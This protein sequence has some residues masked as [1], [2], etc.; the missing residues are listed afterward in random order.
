M[1]KP[2]GTTTGEWQSLA[3]VLGVDL[4]RI[5]N[6]G[7]VGWR[8]FHERKYREA[9]AV[10]RGLTHLDPE[11]IDLYRGYSMAAAK[12]HDLQAAVEALDQ[13]LLLLDGKDDRD[14]DRAQLLALR[15]T[16]LYRA[17]RKAEAMESAEQSLERAPGAPWAEA[18][19]RGLR[20]ASKSARRETTAV[21][22]FSDVMKTRL[23]QVKSGEKSLAW[24][25]GYGDQELLHVFKN[26]A[27][28]LD[29]GH[30]SRARR[31]FAGLVAL[32]QDVPLFHL[33]L[34]AAWDQMG[35]AKAARGEYD[36]AVVAARTVEDGEDLLADAL[37]R[38]ARHLARRGASDG[39]VRDL[40]EALS[41]PPEA[42][43]ED[44]RARANALREGLNK[45]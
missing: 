22:T 45:V 36:A 4:D 8:L 13:G 5:D 34:A 37:L 28:L 15:A 31:I 35:D 25:I 26:G 41:L 20:R 2:S 40:E 7:G 39:A 3:E 19:R 30:A 21:T 43:S 38:R 18:L 33:A 44:L 27:A 24:A 16:F 29:A 42:I 14:D 17:G 32:D 12:D 1:P 6:L 10:F 23:D 11:N 9:A